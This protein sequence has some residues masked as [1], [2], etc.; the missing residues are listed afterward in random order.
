MEDQSAGG[1]VGAR[2]GRR[3]DVL[4][5]EGGR[6]TGELGGQGVREVD[7]TTTGGDLGAVANRD[8]LE[9]EAK[10]IANGGGEERGAVGVALA[11]ADGEATALQVDVLDAERQGLAQP[12]PRA[13]QKL[14]DQAERPLQVGQEPRD[15]AAR[16]DRGE[17]S[18]ALSPLEAGQ[19]RG[20]EIEDAAVEED[21]SAEGLVDGG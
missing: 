7:L 19:L 4:P 8:L 14:G 6:G 15:V 16:Q 11:A 21:E 1:G 12:E 10:R 9:L 5:G 2:A 13:V 20:G 18:G 17:V 3:E